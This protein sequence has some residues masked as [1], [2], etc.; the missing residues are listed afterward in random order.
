VLGILSSVLFLGEPFGLHK[1]LGAV[2]TLSGVALIQYLS[3]RRDA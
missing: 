3:A 1:A 2:C